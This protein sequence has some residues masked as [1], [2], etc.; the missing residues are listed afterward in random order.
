MGLRRRAEQRQPPDPTGV[1]GARGG[2]RDQRRASRRGAERSEDA[3]VSR[4]ALR[5]GSVGRSPGLPWEHAAARNT[6]GARTAVRN[7]VGRA[8]QSEHPW[9][10]RKQQGRSAAALSPPMRQLLTG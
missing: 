10:A 2:P 5:P 8:Q 1:D 7:T 9:G 4:A 3:K 6:R